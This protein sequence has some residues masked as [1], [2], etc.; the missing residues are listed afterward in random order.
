MERRGLRGSNIPITR[1]NIMRACIRL[2]LLLMLLSASIHAAE[3]PFPRYKPAS[4]SPEPIDIRS[5]AYGASRSAPEA[6]EIGDVAPDFL[7]PRAGG[8]TVSL[9]E[10]L[11]RGPVTLIFYRG[12]W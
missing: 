11:E 1:R 8:G 3:D 2:S 10:A 6:L 7:L 12:H 9:T 4:R 5:N